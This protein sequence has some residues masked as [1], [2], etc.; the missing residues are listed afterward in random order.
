MHRFPGGIGKL[1]CAVASAI[2]C[3][4][5]LSMANRSAKQAAVRTHHC[6]HCLCRPAKRRQEKAGRGARP[7]NLAMN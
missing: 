6:G 5:G 4:R 7:G 1:R 3:I 2:R